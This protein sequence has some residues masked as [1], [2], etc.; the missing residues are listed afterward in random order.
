MDGVLVN[1]IDPAL[2]RVNKKLSTDKSKKACVVRE[3]TGGGDVESRHVDE[4]SDSYSKETTT[5]MLECV[6]ND[7]AWWA[8]LPPMKGY[9]KLWNLISPY[10]P[11]LITGALKYGSQEGKTEWVV[12]WLHPL[13]EEIIMTHSKYEY[14]L[15]DGRTGILIDD[16][17]KYYM[18]FEEHGG[19]VIVHENIDDT[20]K[21]LE[22][23]I[24]TCQI[25]KHPY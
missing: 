6:A 23:I 1:F 24:E 9:E 5:Y 22:A 8:G 25:K 4:Q 14:A 15:R 13:P 17:P 3:V 21:K 7:K 12:E 20:I 18:P 10:N 2:E 19:I 11:H 16:M